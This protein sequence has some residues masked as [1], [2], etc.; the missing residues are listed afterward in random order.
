[1]VLDVEVD[2]ANTDDEDLGVLSPEDRQKELEVY[3]E[4][5]RL[6]STIT[7]ADR[8]ID[9]T[10]NRRIRR[11]NRQAKELTLYAERYEAEHG[12]LFPPEIVSPDDP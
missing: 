1:M 8:E 6:A 12:G 10:Y 9:I 3:Y 5:L 11:A 4:K 7:Q 2:L